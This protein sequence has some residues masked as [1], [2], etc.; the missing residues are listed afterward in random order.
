PNTTSS[1]PRGSPRRGEV[2]RAPASASRGDVLPSCSP[3]D[4]G[5]LRHC[6][7]SPQENRLLGL[8]G[9]LPVDEAPRRCTDLA[10]VDVEDPEALAPLH[11]RAPRA[12]EP[13]MGVRD[14]DVVA[15][16]DV[17]VEEDRLPEGAERLDERLGVLEA[18][19]RVIGPAV[20][21]EGGVVRREE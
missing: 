15:P 10:P 2:S 7:T 8:E 5:K 17:A 6:P 19:P 11:R 14:A 16:V 21:D 20:F 9:G 4:E 3:L 13:E 1:A 12:E 18:V